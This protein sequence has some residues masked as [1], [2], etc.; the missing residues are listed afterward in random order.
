VS[1][2]IYKRC[3]CRSDDGKDLGARCPKLRRADGSWNPRHGTWYFALEL[4]PGPGGKRK[5]MRRGGFG[6][7]DDAIDARDQ[8]K[9]KLGKGADPSSRILTGRFLADWLAGRPDLKRTTKRGYGLIITTYLDPILG[10]VELDKLGGPGGTA[11]VS[12]MV[13]TIEGWNASLAAGKPVRKYQRHVGPA[14]MQRI[15]ACLRAALNDA[16]DQGLIAY[17]PATRVRMAPE[18]RQRPVVWTAGRAA[19]FWDAY[20]RELAAAKAA[21]GGRHVDA[22]DIWKRMALR[23]ARVMVWAPQDTG[24][25]LDYAAGHRLSALFEVIASTGM[26]RGEACGLPW[27]DV[28]LAGAELAVT[29]ERVQVGWEAVEDEPKSEAGRRPI[30]LDKATVTVFRQHR[31]RQLAERLA[32][33]DAWVESGKVF[34]REDGSALHPAAVTELF[35]R[36]AFAAGLPPVN[37]HALRH[38]AA[39]YALAAGLDIKIVSARL[40]HSTSALTRDVYTSVLPDVARAAAEATAAMIPRRRAHP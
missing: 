9:A 14:A 28:D 6:S 25:F 20:R 22:F 40:G 5:Q 17:N 38:G 33:Q 27:T 32:W 31:K 30:A 3:K 34:T 2:P 26:R 24:A 37:L 10:H 35:E 1:E 12:E 13:A 8:A 16:V 19:A 15:R 39:T 7:R 21:A 11:Y 23:P 4:P 29:T 36:L 18:K